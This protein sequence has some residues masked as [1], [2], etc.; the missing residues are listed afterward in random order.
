MIPF[1]VPTGGVQS[2]WYGST[3]F[4]FGVNGQTIKRSSK[5]CGNQF[6]AASERYDP[7]V[8]ITPR[9]QWNFLVSP[10]KESKPSD[11]YI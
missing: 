2:S 4:L 7:S 11:L 5:S 3:Y 10:L 8:T 6:G 9:Q 1:V